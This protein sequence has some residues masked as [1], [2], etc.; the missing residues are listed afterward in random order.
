MVLRSNK[1]CSFFEIK[2]YFLLISKIRFFLILNFYAF[3]SLFLIFFF[4]FILFKYFY[5]NIFFVAV[6]IFIFFHLSLLFIHIVSEYPKRKKLYFIVLRYGLNSLNM[7]SFED[8]MKYPCYRIVCIEALKKSGIS[9]E[10][11]NI[12]KKYPLF[13]SI[14]IENRRE[15]F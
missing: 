6:F 8:Y 10:I 1:L 2:R 14:K 5:L 9:S 15:I 12:K 11:K 4:S 3:V 13:E 7:K